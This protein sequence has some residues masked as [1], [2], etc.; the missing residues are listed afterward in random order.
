MLLKTLTNQLSR[1]N[2]CAILRDAL[3]ATVFFSTSMGRIGADF[4]ALLPPIFEPQLL[5]IVTVNNWE[6]NGIITLEKNIKYL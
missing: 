1:I 4:Q 5:Y 3:D 2:D 6:E